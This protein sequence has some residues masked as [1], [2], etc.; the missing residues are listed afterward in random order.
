M[1]YLAGILLVLIVLWSCSSSKSIVQIN[2]AE[3]TV[4]S[5]EYVVLVNELG[6]DTYMATRAKPDWYHEESFY[7]NYNRLYTNEWNLRVQN[8]RYNQPYYEKIDYDHT[9]NYGKEVEYMLYWYFQF[10]ME[11][12]DF[13]LLITDQIR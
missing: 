2:K 12:Y 5:V 11:K 13:K 10:M 4:D 9:I 6:F 8:Y 3:P 1:K 7:K